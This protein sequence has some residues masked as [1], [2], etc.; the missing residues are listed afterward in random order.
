MQTLKNRCADV[1]WLMV[2]EKASHAAHCC[3]LCGVVFLL[4]CS[5]RRRPRSLLFW[6]DDVQYYYYLLKLPSLFLLI[7]MY[8]RFSL[9]SFLFCFEF[10]PIVQFDRSVY[11]RTMEAVEIFIMCGFKLKFS[12]FVCAHLCNAK[13]TFSCNYLN[14]LFVHCPMNGRTKKLIKLLFYGERCCADCNN[15]N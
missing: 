9:S 1:M 10:L 4:F 6:F 2:H 15:N 14:L 11:Q 7:L 12:H 8:I 13:P 3:L 5:R